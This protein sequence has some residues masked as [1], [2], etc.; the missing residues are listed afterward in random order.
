LFGFPGYKQDQPQRQDDIPHGSTIDVF[1]H[2]TWNWVEDAKDDDDD[3]KIISFGFDI[4]ISPLEIQR[5]F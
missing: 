1:R 5:H 2:P 3:S 4:S